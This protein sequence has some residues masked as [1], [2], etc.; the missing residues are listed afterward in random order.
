MNEIAGGTMTSEKRA[1]FDK[2]QTEDQDLKRQIKALELSDE[3]SQRNRPPMSQ[4]ASPACYQERAEHRSLRQGLRF[5]M[6]K[7]ADT[8]EYRD[9]FRHFLK[10]GE[11]RSL[12]LST[13]TDNP[14]NSVLV[15]QDFAR[16]IENALLATGPMLRIAKV[17]PTTTGA[18]LPWPTANDTG[19]VAAIVG[20]GQQVSEDDPTLSSVIFGAYKYS[21]GLVKV[22]LELLEDSNF[23]LSQWLAE[24]FGRRLSRALNAHFTTGTGTGQPK[25]IVTAATA[26]RTAVGSAGNTG[27][28]EDGTNTIGTDDLLALI[29]SVDPTYRQ[30]SVFQAND[31]TLRYIFSLKDKYGRPLFQQTDAGQPQ[32]IFGYP[33]YTNPNMDTLATGKKTVVFGQHLKYCI[34]QVKDLSILQ[35]R[36]RFADFGQVGFIGFARFDGNLIDAGTH[37][38]KYLVQA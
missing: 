24:Q 15:A 17:Y 28:S 19:N 16:Q 5:E 22:S 26:G 6:P 36:E 31:D 30:G 3:M 18:P 32:N 35:L 11:K 33:A 21:T 34:R 25:G 23:D 7:G 37:P 13:A 20:E 4:I 2:L 1:K 9:N 10:T 14:T 29:H 38:V 8:E 27:G 12:S